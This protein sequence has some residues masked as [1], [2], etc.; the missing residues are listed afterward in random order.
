MKTFESGAGFDIVQTTLADP[1]LRQAVSEIVRAELGK[2]FPAGRALPTGEE[3]IVHTG[4]KLRP[5]SFAIFFD[6]D[7]GYCWLDL[8]WVDPSHRRQGLAT[9]LIDVVEIITETELKLDRLDFG[10]IAENEAMQSLVK[11]R[12]GWRLFGLQFSRS[13][14]AGQATIPACPPSGRQA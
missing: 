11:K 5:T 6:T 9:A 7:E 8:L 3:L 14:K 4:P 1:V 10:T 12:T 13:L 2:G